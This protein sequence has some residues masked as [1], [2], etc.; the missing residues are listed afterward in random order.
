M[1]PVEQLNVHCFCSNH[2]KAFKTL[3]FPSD[4]KGFERSVALRNNSRLIL[5]SEHSC[6]SVV[7]TV[8]TMLPCVHIALVILIR[9]CRSD[10]SSVSLGITLIPNSLVNHSYPNPLLIKPPS[11]HKMK[12]MF[13]IHIWFFI[14]HCQRKF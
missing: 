10:K 5:L 7:Y 12:G 11:S 9:N 4:P 8:S 6:S 3:S 14:G 2:L 1:G 13:K